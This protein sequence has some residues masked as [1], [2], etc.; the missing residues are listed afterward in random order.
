MEVLLPADEVFF[1]EDHRQS[2]N[3]IAFQKVEKFETEKFR[4]ALL[5]KTFQFPRMK[6]KVVKFIGRVFF[7]QL[8]EAEIL[9]NINRCMVVKT[10]VHNE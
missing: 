1:L 10:G 8:S 2:G 9:R 6:S 7:Q 5:V 4:R 3:I